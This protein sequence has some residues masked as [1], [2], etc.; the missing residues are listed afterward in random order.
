[1]LR[2]LIEEEERTHALQVSA[3]LAA[4]SSP[5]VARLTGN[6]IRELDLDERS[7]APCRAFVG[8]DGLKVRIE[9]FSR[10]TREQV[11][12]ACRLEMARLLA[13]EA[14]PML[15]LD[16]PLAHTD[17]D[18]HREALSLFRELAQV[19]QLIIFTCHADRYAPLQETGPAGRIVLGRPDPP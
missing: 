16:D 6:T 9:L 14:R 7:L 18:R 12:L 1:L 3:R 4:L 15:L 13:A 11:A 2:A 19:A 17:P 10:G 5:T 8:S